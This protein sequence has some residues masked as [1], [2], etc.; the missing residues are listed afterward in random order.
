MENP[1]PCYGGGIISFLDIAENAHH[2]TVGQY[3][4]FQVVDLQLLVVAQITYGES[5]VLA[6][7]PCCCQLLAERRGR[8]KGGGHNVVIIVALGENLIV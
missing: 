8:D 3:V 1:P 5:C 4:L 6:A 2:D 7:L